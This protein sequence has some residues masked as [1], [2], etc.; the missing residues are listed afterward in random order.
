M[1]GAIH[2]AEYLDGLREAGFQNLTLQ[3]AKPIFLPDEI[4]ST[5]LAEPEIAAF[6]ASGAGVV[7]ITVYGE[8]SG[9]KRPN[10]NKAEAKAACCGPDSSCC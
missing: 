5:F 8:K 1:S 6:R 2:Q 4:L 10:L 9:E 7:S 3:K